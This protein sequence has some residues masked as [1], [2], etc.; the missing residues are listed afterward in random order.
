[1][2]TRVTHNERHNVY[3]PTRITSDYFIPAIRIINPHLRDELTG[4]S[5][6]TK[7]D[8]VKVPAPIFSGTVEMLMLNRGIVAIV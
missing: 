3:Y 7:I 6:N 5:I 8:P 1:M 4:R 2:K